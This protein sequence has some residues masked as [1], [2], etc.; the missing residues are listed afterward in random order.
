MFSVPEGW[1]YPLT[2]VLQMIFCF[3]KISIKCPCGYFYELNFQFMKVNIIII[4]RKTFTT[5]LL[6]GTICNIQIRS[7]IL[8]WCAQFFL[9]CSNEK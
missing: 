1:F 8:L 6:T 5:F 7:Y 2:V 3:N 4:N 9:Q